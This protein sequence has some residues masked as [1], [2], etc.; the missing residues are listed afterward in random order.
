VFTLVDEFCFIILNIIPFY[1]YLKLGFFVW[2]MHPKLKGALF[3]YNNILRH[4]LEK[5]KDQIQKFI[6]DIKNSGSELAKE[7]F[8][9]GMSYAKGAMNDP[10]NIMKAAQMMGEAQKFVDKH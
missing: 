10:S 6:D 1:A 5:H 7:G 2:L 3:V 8:K 9:E 4:I